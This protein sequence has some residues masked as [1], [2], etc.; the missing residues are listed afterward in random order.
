[1]VPSKFC[2]KIWNESWGY[3]WKE[4]LFEVNLGHW[5]QNG[6][7]DDINFESRDGHVTMVVS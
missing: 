7:D 4:R 5:A 2:S 3:F 6:L 1:M